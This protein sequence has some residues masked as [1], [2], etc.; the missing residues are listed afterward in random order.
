MFGWGWGWRGWEETV[1][2]ETESEEPEWGEEP[3]IADDSGWAEVKEDPSSCQNDL[4]TSDA[5]GDD[6]NDYDLNPRWCG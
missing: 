3:E 1:W 5:Y 2:E 4:S 6:C